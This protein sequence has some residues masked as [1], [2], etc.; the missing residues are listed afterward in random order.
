MRKSRYGIVA[1]TLV[2]LLLGVLAVTQ[3]RAQ[4]VFSRSLTAENA[5]SLTTLIAQISDRN[6]ALRDEILALQLR[7]DAAQGASQSSEITLRE[8]RD[9]FQQLQVAAAVTPVSGP[10]VEVRIEGPFDDRAMSDL[11]NE[12]RNAG[13]EAIG[14]NG[15][16]VEPR[17]WFSG[18]SAGGVVVDGTLMTSPYRVQAIGSPDTISVALTR[19]GGIVGQFGLIYGRTR[20][21]VAQQKLIDLP[22]APDVDFQ[23]AKPVR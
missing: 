7:L 4:D 10:G 15:S 22:A 3:Y 1:I 12:I 2:A 11:V 5:S 23:V 19:T 18:S 14:I 9:Q 17:A 13:A 8:L 20:F 6:S 21:T 16:R